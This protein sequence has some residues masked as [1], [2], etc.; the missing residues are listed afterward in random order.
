MKKMVSFISALAMCAVMAAPM[1]SFADLDGDLENQEVITTDGEDPT[2]DPTPDPEEDGD[3][4]VTGT[5]TSYSYDE[6]GESESESYATLKVECPSVY[7]VI[8]PD[9]EIDITAEK[10]ATLK[11]SA[12]NVLIDEGTTLKVSVASDDW[13][14]HDIKEG[15]KAT[16]DYSITKEDGTPVTN[17]AVLEVTAG[18]KS[19]T[20]TMT[21]KVDENTIVKSGTYE[22]KLT[23]TVGV[24]EGDTAVTGYTAVTTPSGE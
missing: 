5:E 13:K 12:S 2:P 15:S 23:F 22:D 7:T 9:G 10:Q 4:I 18:T 6:T 24:Y 14:L 19:K 16:I 20:E 3:D 21:A 11:V 8:I 17:G 1:A